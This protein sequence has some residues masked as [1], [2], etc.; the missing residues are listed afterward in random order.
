MLLSGE[1]AKTQPPTIFVHVE[2]TG[3]MLLA[4]KEL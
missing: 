1:W 2:N 3:R 4:I